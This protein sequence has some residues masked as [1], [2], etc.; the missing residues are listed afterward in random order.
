MD[1]A[2]MVTAMG[3]LATAAAGDVTPEELLT[4]LVEVAA[5]HL[6]VDGAGVMICDGAALRVLHASTSSLDELE[7]LQQRLQEG[8]CQ[9]AVLFQSEIVVDD[10]ADPVQT[11]WPD[12]VDVSLAAGFRSVVAVALVG[13][14]RVWGSLDLYRRQ[15]STWQVQELEWARLLAHLAVSYLVIGAER[16]V[17]RAAEKELAHRSTH[18][19]LTGLANRV[20]LFDRLDHAL[21]TARRHGRLDAVFF[22][23]LN[24]FKAINDTFGHAAG[25]Q[26]LVTVARRL[27]VT[28][29]EEDTLARLG[30][31]EFVL[32]CEDLPQ[33]DAVELSHHIAAVEHHVRAALRRPIRL[34]EGDVT[35][36]AS[37]GVAV[38]DDDS[39][40]DLLI[41][42]ADGSMYREKRRHW[43]VDVRDTVPSPGAAVIRPRRVC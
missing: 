26:V 32:L 27:S 23:D 33:V 13:R 35:V 16:D 34:V 18:D 37:I 8:P 14:G 17:A 12:Y 28:L 9:D 25:D 3:E 7:T 36:S 4:H 2:A 15:A 31:D 40:A 19:A 30:G 21:Q 11:G 20:L 39:T 41:A 6:D 22:I 5:Q 43:T 24:G 29:R 38:S 42:D 10:L 1:A